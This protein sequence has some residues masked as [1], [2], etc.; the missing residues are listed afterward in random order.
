VER[1]SV[2]SAA[3]AASAVSAVSAT[4]RASVTAWHG[5]RAL[6]SQEAVSV[7]VEGQCM[8]PRIASGVT[9]AVAPRAVYWPGDVLA[10][11][12]RDGRLWLHRLIGWRPWNGRWCLVTR[13][14]NGDHPDPPLPAAA[15]LGRAAVPVSWGDRRRA[16]ATYLR[17][18]WGKIV[19]R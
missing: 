13:A 19:R 3:S 11:E 2:A 17:L 9:V 16:V 14:D 15:V 18:A 4:P 6:A 7:R 8:A 1:S 12:G 10:F 5:V